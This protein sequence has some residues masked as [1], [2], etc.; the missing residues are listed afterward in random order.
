MEEHP[1]GLDVQGTDRPLRGRVESRDDHRI[2]MA[3][4]VLGAVGSNEI[5]VDDRAAAGVS[6]PGFWELLERLAGAPPTA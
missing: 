3:F 5:E 2:A 4:G 6:F 1:D